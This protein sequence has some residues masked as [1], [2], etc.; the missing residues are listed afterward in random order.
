MGKML[1]SKKANKGA[2]CVAG[3]WTRHLE[4]V[5]AY[6]QNDTA[7]WGETGLTGSGS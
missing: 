6:V 4:D 1:E 7:V 2:A 3:L 5:E